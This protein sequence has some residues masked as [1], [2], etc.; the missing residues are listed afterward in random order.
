MIM[1]KLQQQLQA[2]MAQIVVVVVVLNAV[3]L[4]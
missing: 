2:P 4:P 1:I 3:S